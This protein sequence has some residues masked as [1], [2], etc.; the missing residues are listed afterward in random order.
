MPS[1][2]VWLRIT[3]LGMLIA[4][5]SPNL[6]MSWLWREGWMAMPINGGSTLIGWAQATG[7]ALATA[8]HCVVT[9]STGA[10]PSRRR[11]SASSSLRRTI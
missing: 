5:S 1:H 8:R 7:A 3:R 4:N 6:I 11:P 9:I 10:P 2:C